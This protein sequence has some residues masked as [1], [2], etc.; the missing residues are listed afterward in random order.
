MYLVR[1]K[2][3]CDVFRK[4]NIYNLKLNVFHVIYIG[5]Q[6]IS[7]STSQFN[8]LIFSFCLK[9]LP[10]NSTVIGEVILTYV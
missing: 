6:K 10:G 7:L 1:E 4:I 8:N 2:R 5:S 9:S 3:N